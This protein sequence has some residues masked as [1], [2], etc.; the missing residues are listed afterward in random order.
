MKSVFLL[1]DNEDALIFERKIYPL[2]FL[3]S[4]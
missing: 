3:N 4:L 1:T 2:L